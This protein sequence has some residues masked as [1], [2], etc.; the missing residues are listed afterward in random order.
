MNRIRVVSDDQSPIF[1]QGD[2]FSGRT[3]LVLASLGLYRDEGG[4]VQET[5]YGLHVEL[6]VSYLRLLFAAGEFR[7]DW[8]VAE[9]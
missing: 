4:L 5:S 9:A 8:D 1:R 3:R 2:A 6:P 7:N